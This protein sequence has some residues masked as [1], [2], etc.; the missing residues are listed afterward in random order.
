M[1]EIAE[2]PEESA[3]KRSRSDEDIVKKD[4]ELSSSSDS[5]QLR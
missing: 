1:D 5:G 3:P 4:K 2:N